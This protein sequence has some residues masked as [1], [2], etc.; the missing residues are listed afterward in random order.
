[1]DTSDI[2]DGQEVDWKMHQIAFL[3]ATEPE[4]TLNEIAKKL[5]IH[6]ST[7]GRKLRTATELGV[8]NKSYF[9][10]SFQIQKS[11]ID[12]LHNKLASTLSESLNE[13]LQILNCE[14]TPENSLHCPQIQIV[15]AS[16]EFVL[17]NL[18]GQV[19]EIKQLE[20]LHHDDQLIKFGRCCNQS[21]YS[22][23]SNAIDIAQANEHEDTV[24]GV[25]WGRTLK[26]VTDFLQPETFADLQKWSYKFV[27][28]WGESIG[29]EPDLEVTKFNNHASLTPSSL[30]KSLGKILPGNSQVYSLNGVPVMLPQ[31]V[32]EHHREAFE[33]YFSMISDYK[34]IFGLKYDKAEKCP[35][36]RFAN[37][38]DVA[39]IALGSTKMPGRFLSPVLM[40]NYLDKGDTEKMQSNI[41]GD[42]G[43]VLMPK[44]TSGQEYLDSFSKRWLGVTKDHLRNCAKRAVSRNGAGVCAFG[45]SRAKSDVALAGIQNGLI[46]NLICDLQ[47]ANGLLELVKKSIKHH[48]SM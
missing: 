27:P 44:E 33:D 28:L 15:C 36:E 8:F 34:E 9:P 48:R 29:R 1:M 18:T 43:G 38:L 47:L 4:K 16:D 26:S 2:E 11:V 23:F 35:D 14:R 42:V 22:V 41:L 30:A 13:Y 21:V 6:P 32:Q 24:V 45:T 12:K 37:R 31:S 3:C 10:R 17:P 40:K 7:V 20:R 19:E 39:L 46:N 5:G 25:S